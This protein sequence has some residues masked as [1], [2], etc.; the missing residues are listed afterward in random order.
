MVSARE[1]EYEKRRLKGKSRPLCASSWVCEIQRSR[2]GS[3]P[4]AASR[5]RVLGEPKHLEQPRHLSGPASPETTLK[6]KKNKCF[7]SSF[8]WA[9]SS[10]EKCTH[11]LDKKKTSFSLSSSRSFPMYIHS[12]TVITWLAVP[13]SFQGDSSN[14][15]NK[16]TERLLGLL[17]FLLHL[18]F[19]PSLSSKNS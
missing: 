3:R 13:H 8:L 18:L 12:I 7:P 15:P 1:V 14:Q 9:R 5:A 11:F 10:L 6:S 17:F 16:L 2:S 19:S 4:P